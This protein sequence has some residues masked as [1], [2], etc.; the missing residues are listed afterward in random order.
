MTITSIAA[1]AFKQLQKP[2]V[3]D[4]RTHAE[5]DAEALAG[6]AHFPLQELDHKQRHSIP[7][8]CGSST[9]ATSLSALCR[10]PQGSQEPPSSYRTHL[11]QP[12]NGDSKAG[13]VA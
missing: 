4:V 2:R 11:R 13:S 7:A 1:D 3:L 5:V 10:R 8:L 12:I 6:A 9:R